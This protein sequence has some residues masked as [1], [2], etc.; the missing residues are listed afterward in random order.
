[1]RTTLVALT[2][3]IGS[4]VAWPAR[5]DP[6]TASESTFHPSIGVWT[7]AAIQV[8]D[9]G[10]YLTGATGTVGLDLRLL[11]QTESWARAGL[12]LDLPIAPA[13]RHGYTPQD[14]DFLGHWTPF[15]GGAQQKNL[16]VSFPSITFLAEFI[17]S[18]L[19]TLDFSLGL[20][21]VAS[22]EHVNIS[23]D[24]FPFLRVGLGAGF[25]VYD[26]PGLAVKVN[27]RMDYQGSAWLLPQAGVT[28]EF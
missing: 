4:V 1:M 19:V 12:K 18:S 9:N 11:W 14:G 15:R 7:G 25:T 5:A 6:D 2:I 8:L 26:Q 17:V 21:A 28:V 27:L 24:S 3:L 13:M 10:G 16:P 20:A 22:S 23:Y